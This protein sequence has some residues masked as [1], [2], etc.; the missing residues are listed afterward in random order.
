MYR[1]AVGVRRRDA[2]QLP[3]RGRA[4]ASIALVVA[5]N[6]GGR[7]GYGKIAAARALGLPAVLIARPPPPEAPRVATV[8]AALAWLDAAAGA[9]G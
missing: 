3:T 6:A 8:A 9:Q 5:K 4:G 7:A 2:R 1:P